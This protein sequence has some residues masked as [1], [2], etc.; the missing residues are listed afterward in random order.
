MKVK[1]TR[2]LNKMIDFLFSLFRT[3]NYVFRGYCK[4]SELN[5]TIV[6]NHQDL[7]VKLDFEKYEIELLKKYGKYSIQYIPSYSNPIDWVA[8]AQH[9]GLPT[10]LIDWSFD[11]FCALFFSSFVNKEPEGDYYKIIYT[12][13]DEHIYFDDIPIFENNIMTG[14]NTNNQLL[15]QYLNFVQSFLMRGGIFSKIHH[16]KLKDEFVSS[17]LKHFEEEESNGKNKLFFCST[18]DSNPRIIAQ[19]GLFQIPRRFEDENSN[20]CV[21]QDIL[22]SVSGKIEIHKSLRPEIISFLEKINVS[23][24]RL[25]PDIASICLYLKYSEEYSS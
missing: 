18:Y 15:D 22:S 10:R 7:D 3:N 16:G 25:F 12:D 11:P 6:R 5:P 4:E 8:S 17:V 20:L 24:P 9:Y 23:T 1:T 13:L 2:E 19:R 21:P 14:V